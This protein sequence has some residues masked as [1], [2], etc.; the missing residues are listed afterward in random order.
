MPAE[1]KFLAKATKVPHTNLRC[2][3]CGDIRSVYE[4]PS[5]TGD[6]TCYDVFPGVQICFNQFRTTDPLPCQDSRQ[7]IM[8]IN[9]CLH[10]CHECEFADGTSSFIGEGD[11]CINM[12]RHAPQGSRL[13]LG[14]YEGIGLFLDMEQA[15]PSLARAME[16]VQIDLDG[17]CEKLR[18]WTG[19]FYLPSNPSITHIFSELYQVDSQ[20]QLSYFRIKVLE[21]LLFLGS[22]RVLES[23]KT[24]R[25]YPKATVDAVKA[26]K[27]KMTRNLREYMTLEGLAEE[28][29]ISLSALKSCFRDIYGQPPYT[30]LKQYR[31]QFAAKLL[32]EGA[33][34]IGWIA[35]RV[36]YASAGKFSAAFKSVLGCSPSD[37]RKN[38]KPFGP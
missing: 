35:D 16:G 30:Y 15:P 27:A 6:M 34:S 5:A 3:S 20:I 21:L 22:D 25:Y 12:F 33:K 10:G 23:R 28:H 17:L 37:Y 13:P 7:N 29:G 32:V 18:L 36:G 24:Q 26:V 19:C 38:H 14:Y 1:H 2:R 11:L 4:I 8:E 31:V 9:Y